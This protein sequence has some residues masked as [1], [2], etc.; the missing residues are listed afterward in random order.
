MQYNKCRL[1]CPYVTI[2]IFAE[3]YMKIAYW[4]YLFIFIV[5]VSTVIWFAIDTSKTVQNNSP[6]SQLTNIKSTPLVSIPNFTA[7]F[8]IITG[9]PR[10]F[11]NSMYLNRSPEAFIERAGNPNLIRIK[12]VGITWDEFFKTLP[13]TLTQTCLVTGDGETLCNDGKRTLKF[14]LNLKDTPDAL[15]LPIVPND[16]LEVIYGTFSEARPREVIDYFPHNRL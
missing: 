16:N 9:F 4:F 8:S 1:I 15:T 7:T 11:S 6:S 13:F 5:I 3:T 14:Y 10:D 2:L 12:K